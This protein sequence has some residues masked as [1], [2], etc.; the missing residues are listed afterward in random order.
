V[1]PKGAK[2]EETLDGFYLECSTRSGEAF[3]L[4][5]FT[6]VWSGFSLTGI[7]GSQI[8]TGEFNPGQSLLGLIF[9]IGSVCLLWQ[10]LMKICGEVTLELNH[11]TLFY[12]TG[13]HPIGRRKTVVWRT[14]DLAREEIDSWGKGGR[15]YHAIY[16]EGLE[17]HVIGKDLSAAHRYF[18]IQVLN[19]HIRAGREVTQ[20]RIKT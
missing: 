8:T 11:G 6:L 12:F 14:I 20:S 4:V 17:R 3:F 18:V 2:Y 15:Q 7:Y 10:T 16:L 19:E 5:P 9:V 1:A 13:I